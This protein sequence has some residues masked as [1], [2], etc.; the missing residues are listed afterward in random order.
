MGIGDDGFLSQIGTEAGFRS[1]IV[2]AIASYFAANGPDANPEIIK[3]R[4]RQVIV[5]APRGGRSDQ[6]IN[7]YLSDRHLND[8]IGWVRTRERANLH[9]KAV[10]ATPAARLKSLATAVPVASERVP[11]VRDIAA[12]LIRCDSIPA[13]LALS[14]AQ[15]WNGTQCSPPLPRDQVRAIVNDLAGRQAARVEAGNGR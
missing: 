12:R 11:A 1:G 14:L 8:I 13:C 6:D 7:R 3:A 9:Q 4:L 10:P 15:A 5:A 2:G